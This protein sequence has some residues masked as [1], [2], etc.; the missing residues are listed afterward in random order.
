[1]NKK[2]GLIKLKKLIDDFHSEKDLNKRVGI[3][4]EYN[5]TL[6]SI[7]HLMEHPYDTEIPK[8]EVW[9]NIR[10]YEGIYQVSNLGRIKSLERFFI[11]NR[12]GGGNRMAVHQPEK[13]RFPSHDKDGYLKISFWSNGIATYNTVHRV[14]AI[15]FLNNDNGYPQ[16]LHKDDNPNNP[17]WDNL[18]WGTQSKNIQDAANK[19]RG[20]RGDKNGM[21]KL[22]NEDVP[23]IRKLIS[24]GFSFNKIASLYN[25]SKS[26][27]KSIRNKRNWTY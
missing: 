8:Q 9:R 6:K 5:S 10:G 1:M 11:K 15:Y 24:K 22:K 12:R 27:I 25:V 13:I 18:E 19:G 23:E 2:C 16:V 14:V 26:T 4:E 3:A 21:A 20:F 17:R 7:I